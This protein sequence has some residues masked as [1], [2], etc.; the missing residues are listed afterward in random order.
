MQGDQ[1]TL[2]EFIEALVSMWDIYMWHIYCVNGSKRELSDPSPACL[3]VICL[4]TGCAFSFI[5]KMEPFLKHFRN[6]FVLS[7][8]AREKHQDQETCNRSS[9]T[10]YLSNNPGNLL[11]I[12]NNC[13]CP[14]CVVSLYKLS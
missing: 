6:A 11:W 2:Y 9:I 8:E 1:N 12:N 4:T 5:T 3:S 10:S 13:D 14:H 7:A